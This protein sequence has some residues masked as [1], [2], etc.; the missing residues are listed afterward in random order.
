MKPY[1]LLTRLLFSP[2]FPFLPF[3][4]TLVFI[5][6]FKSWDSVLLCQGESLDE[7]KELIKT[8]IVKHE[9]LIKQANDLEVKAK[10]LSS[11]IDDDSSYRKADNA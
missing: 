3:L 2:I 10:A 4:F 7:I 9:E 8:D 6:I 5:L 11:L 1:Y